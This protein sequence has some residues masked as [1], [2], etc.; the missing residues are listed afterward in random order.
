[1]DDF[2]QFERRLADALRVRRRP[3]RRSIRGSVDRPG[4]DRRHRAACHAPPAGVVASGQTVRPG[5][6]HDAPR[7]RSHAARRWGVGGAPASCGCRR[8]SRRCLHHRSLRSPRHRPTRRPR[9]R[10][11][12][13]HH[14]Q[15]RSLSRVREASGSRPGRWARPATITRR[16]GFSTAGCSWWAATAATGRRPD[17][18]GAVRPGH[19]DLVRHREHAPAPRRLPGHVAARRQ[20]ARGGCRDPSADRPD[21]G[22]EVYDPASGTWTRHR[23]DGQSATRRPR[24][25]CCATARCSWQVTTAPSCTTPTAGPGPPLGR[26]SHA[27]A[28]V[29]AATLLPDGKVLVAGGAVAR[30]IHAD[31]TRPSSTTQARGPGPRPRTCTAPGT[32]DSWPR[33]CPMARCSCVTQADRVAERLRPDHR[34]LDRTGTMPTECRLLLGHAAVGWHRARWRQERPGCLYRRGLYDPRTGS[35]T[36]ASSMLRCGDG[37]SFTLLLDGTVL[38][39]GGS[40]CNDDGAC[41]SRRARRSCTSLP[42]C[43]RRRCHPSRARPRRS[44]RARPRARPPLPPAAGPVPPNA[45]TWTVTVDNES[46]EPATLFVAEEDEAAGSARRV[47]DPERG[48]SRRHREGDLPLPC[49]EG[50][51]GWIYVNPRPG[52]GGVVGQRGRHRHPRQDR[53]QAEGGGGWLSP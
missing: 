43:R 19:R 1:M 9:A 45:R 48:P 22:A 53:D 50:R 47:R 37:S 5:P 6:R 17:L 24:R 4:R 39:A 15:V 33:C 38:V 41:V 40:D 32:G 3:E 25:R 30:R 27:A 10:A 26:W 18:R 13:R 35:L 34:N 28:T 44:S 46:S 8:S 11:N 21:H 7:G 29:H 36:T 42:A 16:C 20:G 49:Q 31:W 2:D 52:E 12:R 14:P 51:D 23:E